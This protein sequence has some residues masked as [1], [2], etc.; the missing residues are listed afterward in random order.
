MK[1]PMEQPQVVSEYLQWECAAG[2]VL[3]PFMVDELSMSD[4]VV[5]HFGVIPKS[6]A[7]NWHLI[8]DLSYTER[9]SGVD[10]GVC[11][12]QYSRVGVATEKVLK[13]GP[14]LFMAK[15]DI[16]S[17]YRTVPVHPQDWWLLGMQWEGAYF[18]DTKDLYSNSRCSRV[19]SKT[20]GGAVLPALFG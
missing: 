20:A 1:S 7:G 2:R 15:I 5:S 14:G 12:L 16:K 8:V 11:S 3:G 19:D 18:V 9:V 6:S 4:M 10:S 17:A 13:Q